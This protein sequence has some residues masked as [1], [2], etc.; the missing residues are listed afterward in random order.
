MIFEILS[1]NVAKSTPNFE[2]ES[3]MHLKEPASIDNIKKWDQSKYIHPHL[4]Q[5]HLNTCV[6]LPIIIFF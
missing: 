4:Y 6:F 5:F 3:E 2:L 1:G